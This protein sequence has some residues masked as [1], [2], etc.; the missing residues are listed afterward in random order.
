MHRSRGDL[1]G[2]VAGVVIDLHGN[3]KWKSASELDNGLNDVRMKIQMAHREANYRIAQEIVREYK[4]LIRSTMDTQDEH[5][6]AIHREYP[7][8][9]SG[10][11]SRGIHISRREQNYDAFNPP[12]GGTKRISFHPRESDQPKRFTE[13]IIRV[14]SDHFV[15]QERGFDMSAWK[16]KAWKLP[17]EV[18]MKIWEW[19][20]KKGIVQRLKAM[21]TE[22]YRYDTATGSF[23]MRKTGM[24]EYPEGAIY[25]GKRKYKPYRISTPLERE[26]L[27]ERLDYAEYED[28][29][30]GD[31]TKEEKKVLNWLCAVVVNSN[32]DRDDSARHFLHTAYVN[33]LNDRALIDN[34]LDEC[35]VSE[36]LK[37]GVEI[38]EFE[39]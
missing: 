22:G 10:D 9:V 16:G 13:V 28:L 39:D 37:S 27:Y 38:K 21:E 33:V 8:E 5:G 7:S 31:F 18:K 30:F 1:F 35:Y 26:R 17:T 34:I 14:D 2:Q 20:V 11:L 15:Y 12:K 19:G 29:R 4:Y 36:G 24:F 23:V 6:R 25:K 3:F 32:M